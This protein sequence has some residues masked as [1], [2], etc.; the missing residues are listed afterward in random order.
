[1]EIDLSQSPLEQSAYWLSRLMRDGLYMLKTILLSGAL[2]SLLVATFAGGAALWTN[3]SDAKHVEELNWALWSRNDP[4]SG[5]YSHTM[6]AHLPPDVQRYFNFMIA[7]G[8]P[9]RTINR[10]EMLGEFGLG[11]AKSH[12]YYPISA[13]QYNAAPTAFTWTMKTHDTVMAMNGS[14]VLWDKTSHTKFWLFG[15]LPVARLGNNQ[16]HLRSAF[17]RLAIEMAAWSP[18]ALLPH[19]GGEWE[20]VGDNHIRV[21]VRHAGLTQSVDIEIGADG[22]P[23]SFSIERWSDANVDKEFRLQPFGAIAK[24]YKTI[25]G[26]TIVSEVEVGN[27]FGTADY[28]PFFKAVVTNF[29]YKTVE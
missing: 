13:T 27:H 9:L 23:L 21:T 19:F 14:D 11:D 7:E 18:V 20:S 16:D 29:E 2:F 5:N 6:V 28:F 15:V 12:N 3:F 10:I 8:T 22:A 4:T 1:M 26:I 25:D 17:G 24:A